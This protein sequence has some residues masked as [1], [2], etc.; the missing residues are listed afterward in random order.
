M[1]WGVGSKNSLWKNSQLYG[2][3][4]L[5]ANFNSDETALFARTRAGVVNLFSME[6]GERYASFGGGIATT[7]RVSAVCFLPDGKRLLTGEGNGSLCLRSAVDGREIWR[8]NAY[9]NFVAQCG[10]GP[11]AGWFYTVVTNRRRWTIQFWTCPENRVIGQTINLNEPFFRARLSPSG[12]RLAVAT[13]RPG[14]RGAGWVEVFAAPTGEKQL[15]LRHDQSIRAVT[16]SDDERWIATSYYDNKV[17]VWDVVT[18]KAVQLAYRHGN[19]VMDITFN[20]E[21][22]QVA[23]ASA[24]GTARIWDIQSGLP[25]SP[26]LPHGGG[27]FALAWSFDGK[28]LAVGC[29]D[30]HIYLWPVP[31]VSNTTKNEVVQIAEFLARTRML[32][33]GQFEE[34][35]LKEATNF[36]S[37]QRELAARP[38]TNE[39]LRW[40]RWLIEGGKTR[41]LR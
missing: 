35:P 4:V 18:G 24:D 39:A 21:S 32:P 28:W 1:L 23:T 40:T 13:G 5:D 20:R 29:R 6:T 41:S 19:T 12:Q 27:C 9:T 8:T 11:Q 14:D 25:L 15:E 30:Q 3:H 33:S 2:G 16:W 22:T 17:K 37:L 36:F 7:S 26:P 34:V 10:F 31:S 38:L